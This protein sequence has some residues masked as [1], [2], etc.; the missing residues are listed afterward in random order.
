MRYRTGEIPETRE[1]IAD[2]ILPGYLAEC[3]R[4]S[5]SGHWAAIERATGGFIGWFQFQRCADGAD[6][7][8]LSDRLCQAAWGRGTRRRDPGL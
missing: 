1:E 3:G 2:T 4:S 5:D 8:E 6:E 7:V